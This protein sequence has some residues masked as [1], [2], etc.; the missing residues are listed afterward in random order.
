MYQTLFL[1]NFRKKGV[2]YTP[3]DFTSFDIVFLVKLKFCKMIKEKV[4]RNLRIYYSLRQSNFRK[5]RVTDLKGI[6]YNIIYFIFL[7]LSLF[8]ST[9]TPIIN[10]LFCSANIFSI[11]FLV[12]SLSSLFLMFNSF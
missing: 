8:F 2:T 3:P 6:N 11:C 9:V 12:Y 5:F 10:S 4:T 1:N 7:F